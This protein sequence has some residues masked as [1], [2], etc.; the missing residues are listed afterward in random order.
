MKTM[1]KAIK[2]ATFLVVLVSSQHAFSY[3]VQFDADLSIRDTNWTFGDAGTTLTV[4]QWNPAD[5]PGMTL[6]GVDV[7]LEGLLEG[8]YWIENMSVD[9]NSLYFFKQYAEIT[10]QGPSNS[11]EI[12]ALPLAEVGDIP[13]HLR[14]TLTTY[15][16]VDDF[17]GDSGDTYIG[18]QASDVQAGSVAPTYWL[19]QYVGSGTVDFVTTAVGTTMA[20]NMGGNVQAASDIDAGADLIVTYTYEALTAPEPTLFGAMSG[21]FVGIVALLPMRTVRFNVR[22]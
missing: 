13:P 17:D 6:T 14:V 18:N 9:S 5:Y 2:T 15:D 7:Q 21:V 12:V 3:S 10:I 20:G 16:G 22:T 1:I 19:S 8:N 11:L 4:P